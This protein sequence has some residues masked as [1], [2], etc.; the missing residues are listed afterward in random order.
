MKKKIVI[1]SV[2]AVL[3]S[4]CLGAYVVLDSKGNG[5]DSEPELVLGY[6]EVN[7]EGHI[8]TESARFFADKVSELTEGRV[9][10]DIYPS[11]Q[12]GDDARCYQAM[13]MGALD[14]YRGNSMSLVECGKP[15]VSALAL[16][17]IFR[18]REH[19]WNVCDSELGQQI[20]DNIQD[21]TGM[22]GLAY[23]DEGARNFF[24][25]DYPV[26]QLD[27]MK[28][29]KIRVQ[30]TSMMGDMVEAL[31]AKAVPIDYVELY[32]ALQSEAVDGAENPPVS[33]YYNKF[34]KV[35]PYYVKDG[36]T[37][38]PGVILVS[39]ITW[40]NLKPEYQEALKEAA[41]ATQEFNS[42]AIAEA[43]QEAYEALER[44][45]VTIIEPEDLD[46]WRAAM[47]PV[48]EKYGADYLDLIDKIQRMK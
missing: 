30:L 9:M 6:G 44:A 1:G 43:D 37:Y 20:L 14:L 31:G 47:E 11:G 48:Y 23:L 41:R 40:E 7:P 39:R 5:A 29:L 26:R 34:Y 24:T 8:M 21:C 10:V 36:H 4:G 13:E 45:G 15:M 22:I 18:D 2:L 27:N 28:D 33:Y 38:S 19:F 46:A 42:K 25:S 35:A 32:T 17:Y 12:L 16:P 3:V